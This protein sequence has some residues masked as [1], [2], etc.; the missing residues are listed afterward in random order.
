MRQNLVGIGFELADWL[1][2]GGVAH[3]GG[4]A[5]NHNKTELCEQAQFFAPRRLGGD[6]LITPLLAETQLLPHRRERRFCRLLGAAARL[7]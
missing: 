3:G 2:M 6:F 1:Y 7:H 5:P 4:G